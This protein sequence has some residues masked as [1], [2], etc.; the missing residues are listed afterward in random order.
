M[1]SL[2]VKINFICELLVVA[3]T[4]GHPSQDI[5]LITQIARLV[6]STKLVSTILINARRMRTKVTVLTLCVCVCV[7]RLLPSNRAHTTNWTYQHAFRQFFLGFQ[8]TD[9]SKMPSF[10]R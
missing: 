4:C 8:L 5:F 1:G 3:Q 2:E 10:P 9:L 7:P 6:F